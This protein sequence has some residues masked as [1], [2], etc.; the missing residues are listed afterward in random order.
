MAASSMRNVAQ[1][2]KS[3]DSKTVV[4]DKH[5]QY[6]SDLMRLP[7]KDEPIWSGCIKCQR[8]QVD[9]ENAELARQARRQ[10]EQSKVNQILGRAA[11]P[12]RFMDR[13]LDNY[14]VENKGQKKALSTAVRYVENW[15][16]N[17]SAGRCLIMMGP[18]GTGKTHLAIGI[19]RKVL[20]LGGT[21]MFVRAHEAISRIMET[22]RRDSPQTE[23]QVLDS[24]RKP[25]LLVIDEIGRQRGTDNE[26]MMLFEIINRRYDDEKPT[27][28]ISNLDKEGV[29][30]YMD[31]ATIDRL[32]E[33]NGIG[34]I[35][36][37][38]SYRSKL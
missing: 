18:P 31:E 36:E 38:E 3:L 29:E 13:S 28:I 12:Q 27:I 22:Y 1:L 33:R 14:V 20:E 11:I 24:F 4:C 35:F 2:F 19:A 17:R 26:R 16:D 5:G 9:Q 32:R 15:Q 21:S 25:D 30:H 10:M 37:W 34:I 6:Q 23:R 8:E 7:G